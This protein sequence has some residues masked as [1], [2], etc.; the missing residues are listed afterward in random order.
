MARI[1]VGIAHKLMTPN[2]MA[3]K[4]QNAASAYNQ[5]N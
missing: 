2:F 5:Y 4:V 3:F 1:S